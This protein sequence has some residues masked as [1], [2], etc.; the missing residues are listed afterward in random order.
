MCW[1]ENLCVR[2]RERRNFSK[3]VRITF[4]YIF[5]FDFVRSIPSMVYE[6]L[7]SW[8]VWL[9]YLPRNMI[10]VFRYMKRVVFEESCEPEGNVFSILCL[11]LKLYY[12]HSQHFPSFLFSC[13]LPIFSPPVRFSFPFKCSSSHF[14]SSFPF[15]SLSPLSILCSPLEEYISWSF[16]FLFCINTIIKYQWQVKRENILRVALASSNFLLP[17]APTT[18]KI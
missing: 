3:D 2:V 4:P 15:P 7:V 6:S 17:S 8:R 14:P 12:L 5:L 9:P 16:F 11:I 1:R 18:H 13:R 10:V